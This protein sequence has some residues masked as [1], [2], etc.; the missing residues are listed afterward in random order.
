MNDNNKDFRVKILYQIRSLS[1]PKSSYVT[2]AKHQYESNYSIINFVPKSVRFSPINNEEHM[3][4]ISDHIPN[5]WNKNLCYDRIGSDST[6]YHQGNFLSTLTP[7]ENWKG[8][9]KK[10]FNDYSIVATPSYR[11]VPKSKDNNQ[12]L[13]STESNKQNY[14][15]INS[16]RTNSTNAN[17][18]SSLIDTNPINLPGYT[19]GN[20][21]S[22]HQTNSNHSDHKSK[23]SG[24]HVSNRTELSLVSS[25]MSAN[26]QKI[27]SK[28]RSK[29]HEN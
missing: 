2:R 4:V 20:T 5:L 28:L 11:S 21:D 14:E 3:P 9:L 10:I 17:R 6:E 16:S 27:N 19:N 26:K 12:A 25:S 8:D 7:N 15:F 13:N 18:S 24:N 1:R 22:S 23:V 29:N